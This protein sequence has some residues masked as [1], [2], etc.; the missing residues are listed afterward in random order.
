MRSKFW[1]RLDTL[2]RHG[3]ENHLALARDWADL[4]MT[5]AAGTESTA[6][7]TPGKAA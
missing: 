2:L 7:K 6:R 1:R 4:P 3:A 5:P